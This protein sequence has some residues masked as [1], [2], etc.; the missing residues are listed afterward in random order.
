[1]KKLTSLVLTLMLV[2]LCASALA[3]SKTIGIV[4]Q[5]ENGAFKDMREGFIDRIREL[6]YTQEDVIFIE[7]NASGDMSNL[8]TICQG[9]ADEDLAAVVAIAT[10]AT[11]TMVNLESGIP[12]FFISVS[13]PVGAGVITD[14]STPDKN[15]TG[16]SNAIPVDEMFKLSDALTPGCQNYGLIYCAS[17]VNSVTTIDSAKAYCDANSLSYTEAVVTS[18]AEIYEAVLMLIDSGVDAIF[19]PNDS[20]IQDGMSVIAQA[21]IDAK[22]PVYG[23]SAVMVASGAFATISIDDRDIGAYTADML[24]AYLK[25]TPIEEIPAVVVDDFTTVINK[26]TAGAIGTELSE[27]LLNSALILE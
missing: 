23:S 8:S 9:F 14:M 3:E 15:A 16:T 19:C 17:Q 12:T 26:T 5:V 2:L 18:S 24:D 25:G 22:I 11:Q 7:K 13:N 27:E 4:Q 6:G 10:P 1:M 20:V 21:A